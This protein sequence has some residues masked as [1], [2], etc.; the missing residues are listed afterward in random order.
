MADAEV[1]KSKRLCVKNLHSNEKLQNDADRK[2]T[3]SILNDF[4]LLQILNMLDINDLC[5]VVNLN[6][7]FKRVSMMS[8]SG[9]YETFYYPDHFKKYWAHSISYK[10]Q[11]RR[12]LCNFGHLIKLL[13]LKDFDRVGVFSGPR[14]YPIEMDIISKYCAGTLKELKLKIFRSLSCDSAKPLYCLHH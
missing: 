13:K 8:F 1:I 2:G 12:V 6:K 5:N 10:F 3:V 9:R 7:Q 4:C 11:M 14:F